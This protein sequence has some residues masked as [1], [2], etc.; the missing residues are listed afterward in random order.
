MIYQET[1]EYRKFAK[2]WNDINS[3]N[4]RIILYFL[5]VSSIGRHRCSMFRLSA[6]FQPF[7]SIL[8]D[9]VVLD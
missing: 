2:V 5:V 8:S 7:Y 1:S 9:I 6:L 4:R 3:S